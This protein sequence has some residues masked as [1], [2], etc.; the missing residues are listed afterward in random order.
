VEVAYVA[1][2]GSVKGAYVYDG[3]GIL[4]REL[5]P[6]ALSLTW[7]GRDGDGDPVP[8]GIYTV[9]I[10]ARSSD[11]SA[12]TPSA[13]TQVGVNTNIPRPSITW[14]LAEGYTGSNVDSGEFDTWVLIQNP[15]DQAAKARVTFMQPGGAN[16][17]REY[18]LPPRSRFTIH[19]DDILPAA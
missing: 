14:Y 15:G 19:V 16:V 9:Y 7:D 2:A 5:A 17:A 1:P 11:P 3:N 18:S 13:T 4:V 6:G 12:L 8:D 10:E